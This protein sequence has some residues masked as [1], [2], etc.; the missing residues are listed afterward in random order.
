MNSKYGPRMFHSEQS[1]CFLRRSSLKGFPVEAPRSENPIFHFFL[2]RKALKNNSV[3]SVCV[4]GKAK[5][6]FHAEP[7]S[8]SCLNT[9]RFLWQ[10]NLWALFFFL[11]T[12]VGRKITKFFR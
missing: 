12:K 11:R 7:L 1:V 2:L 6:Y 9:V 4:L 5:K 8:A 10:V 3:L